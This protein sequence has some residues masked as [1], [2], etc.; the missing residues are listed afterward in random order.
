MQGSEAGNPGFRAN[1]S[2]CHAGA[3]PPKGAN[4][5]DDGLGKRF[6]LKVVGLVIGCAVL[7]VFGWLVISSV[8]LRFGFI[9]AMLIVFGALGLIAHRFDTKNQRQYTDGA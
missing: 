7:A 6:W 8:F 1:P 2:H 3:A 4:M 9:A 5:D